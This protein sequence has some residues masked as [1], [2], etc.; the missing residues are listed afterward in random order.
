[1][2]TNRL[3]LVYIEYKPGAR[4]ICS[5]RKALL[6]KEE[7]EGFASCFCIS[8]NTVNSTPCRASI[9]PALPVYENTRTD[10]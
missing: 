7:Q 3:S 6:A 10:R 5:T 9:L 8:M 2:L 4:I 1:M